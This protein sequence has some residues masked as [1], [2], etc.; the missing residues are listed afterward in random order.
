M[1]T[2]GELNRLGRLIQ[3]ELEALEVKLKEAKLPP[4]RWI[5][6]EPENAQRILR[7]IDDHLPTM[8]HC[9]AK[10]RVIHPLAKVQGAADVLLAEFC[11]NRQAILDSKDRADALG[12]AI[13]E[14]LRTI[15]K[16]C[17]VDEVLQI[18]QDR[19]Y[20]DARQM[21]PYGLTRFK[22]RRDDIIPVL[23]SVLDDPTIMGQTIDALG[24][25]KAVEAIPDLLPYLHH[26]EWGREVQ[27][28][29]TKLGFQIPEQADI[30]AIDA[31]RERGQR[32]EAEHD[33]TIS[34]AGE[35]VLPFLLEI[36]KFVTEGFG[37]T[38]AYN[39]AYFVRDMEHDAT[40]SFGF[41]TVCDGLPCPLYLSFFMDD[42]ET[43][44]VTCVTNP[45]L[46]EKIEA[47]AD[48]LVDEELEPVTTSPDS[49]HE[50]SKES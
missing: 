10:I 18:V 44:E 14:E 46:Y 48:R 45:P 34:L 38:E 25:L 9:L 49:Y 33:V 5:H 36:V 23:V 29:L 6:S 3:P 17:H 26:E 22:K 4:L 7:L 35:D 42:I 31:Y 32:L 1:T 27:K 28:A 8:N 15:I 12:W 39:L 21:L 41:D 13:A 11:R 19:A 40:D 30:T 2:S 50:T 43:P 47:L 24:K 37:V 20:G 16:A